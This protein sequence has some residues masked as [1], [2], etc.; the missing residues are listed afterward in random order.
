MGTLICVSVVLM[1]CTRKEP[2]LLNNKGQAIS[3]S[4]SVN[5]SDSMQYIPGGSFEMGDHKGFVDQQHP[6]DEF[7]VHSVYVTAFNMDRY[8]I[9]NDQY[10]DFLNSSLQ[11]KQID[12]SD[13][14]IYCAEGKD[15]LF[16]TR[17]SDQYSRISWN[18]DHFY[19]LDNRGN[20]PVTSVM[21]CGAAFY[22]NWK[23]NK[24]GYEPCYNTSTWECD[25]TKDGYRLPTEAEWECAAR[26]GRYNPYCNYPWGDEADQTK[27]NWPDSGDPFENGELPWTTPVGFFNG[28]LQKKDDYN[29]PGSQNAYQTSDGANGYGL[30]DM[31]GNVWQ[32]CN[33][34]YGQNYYESS[35]ANDPTGPEYSEASIMPD[36]KI[37]RAFRG[38]NWFNGE[39]DMLLTDINNGHS[40]VSNR[41]PG[42]Y[43]GPLDPDHPYYHVGFRIVRR[44]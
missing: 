42:F 34:W 33:D 21:W 19:V 11:E 41:D 7:P 13:G 25:F 32:W 16:L 18:G 37:Y 2:A 12:I 24:D 17:E 31:A 3:L 15:V 22:C 40:R 39:A 23:S 43:R 1:D 6:S 28:K 14:K 26:G 5:L 10:C 4:P 20:H 35:P 27:A 30:Y 29:W 9:T 36:G 8:D 44:D 38:G